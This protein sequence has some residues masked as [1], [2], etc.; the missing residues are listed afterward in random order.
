M[1]FGTCDWT[2]KVVR[3]S[4]AEII[5]AC[6]RIPYG[7]TASYAEVAAAAGYHG[8]A[9]AVGNVMANNR[10]PLIVPCHR[11]LAARAGW[12]DIPTGWA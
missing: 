3:H 7:R 10:A 5:A 1:I 4:S 11:V 6:R 2:S 8:A 12:A 9:R